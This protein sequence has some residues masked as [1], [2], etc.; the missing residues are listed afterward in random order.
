VALVT[1]P[2]RWIVFTPDDDGSKRYSDSFENFNADGSLVVPFLPEGATIQV[3]AARGA[4]ISY[5][6]EQN[7]ADEAWSILAIAAI[8]NI[9]SYLAA[10]IERKAYATTLEGQ[11]AAKPGQSGEDRKADLMGYIDRMFNYK[12]RDGIE[13]REAESNEYFNIHVTENMRNFLRDMATC[14]IVGVHSPHGGFVRSHNEQINIDDD[15]LK[16]LCEFTAMW[17]Y[18]ISRIDIREKNSLMSMSS[19]QLINYKPTEIDW[20]VRWEGTHGW[21]NNML[22]HISADTPGSSGDT[23]SGGGT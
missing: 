9:D 2:N 6:G 4:I 21:D 8:E 13:W 18:E 23:P 16:Q 20:T 11:F 1:Y 5:Q 14:L 22:T 10:Q 17:G 3:T 7:P 12:L 15:S 19:E